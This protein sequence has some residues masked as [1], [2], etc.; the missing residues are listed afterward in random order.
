MSLIIREM[1]T[2]TTM[3]CY[4]TPVRMSVIKKTIKNDKSVVKS[5]K[6]GTLVFYWKFKLE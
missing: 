6:I 2:M 1:Q 4:L 5:G 3:R